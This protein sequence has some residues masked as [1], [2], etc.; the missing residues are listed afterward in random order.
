MEDAPE[1]PQET[2]SRIAKPGND[3]ELYVGDGIEVVSDTDDNDDNNAKEIEI[4][5]Y[6]PQI[7]IVERAERRDK[8]LSFKRLI[9]K[10]DG[11]SPFD[12]LGFTARELK[13]YPPLKYPEYYQRGHFNI[14]RYPGRE[15]DYAAANQKFADNINQDSEI[16]LVTSEAGQTALREKN[17][18]MFTLSHAVDLLNNHLEAS[19]QYHK[20]VH[21]T[22]FSLAKNYITMKPLWADPLKEARNVYKALPPAPSNI[23]ANQSPASPVDSTEIPTLNKKDLAQEWTAREDS[24]KSDD[25]IREI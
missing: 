19:W 2:D 22:W 1:Q 17:A 23:I 3:E 11:E 21:P 6:K 15:K 7:P 24:R 16:L 13:E 20:A 25:R 9:K 8:Y 12:I 4:R 18:L 5:D 14:E 10:I